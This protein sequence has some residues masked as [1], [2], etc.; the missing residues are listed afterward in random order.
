MKTYPPGH[1]TRNIVAHDWPPG[2][3]SH[4]AALVSPQ[5]KRFKTAYALGEEARK[6]GFNRFALGLPGAAQWV[7][8]FEAKTA[9]EARE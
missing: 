8:A 9:R 4:M 2:F 6:G 1:F 3:V 5:T 7:V